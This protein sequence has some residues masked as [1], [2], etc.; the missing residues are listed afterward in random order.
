MVDR[1]Q[2]SKIYCL[3]LT[4]II[5]LT[6][7]SALFA[8]TAYNRENIDNPRHREYHI[9]K[10][11][12]IPEIDGRLTDS[13]WKNTVFNDNFLQREPVEGAEP[14][15][16]TSIAAMYD[17]DNLYIAVQCFDSDPRNILATEMRRDQ[18]VDDDDCIEIILDTFDDKRSAF[19]FATNALGVRIDGKINDEGKNV[20]TDWD[21]VWRCKASMDENGWS[22]E[23]AIPWQTL[24]FKEGDGVEWNANFVRTIRRK[25]EFVF[26]KLVSQDYGENGKYIMSEAGRIKGFNGL[27]MGGKYEFIPYLTGGIER[28]RQTNFNTKKLSDYGLDI[29]WNL[30]STLTADFTY[31]TDFAQ[32]EADQEKVNL[33]RFSLYFPEKRSFFLE[34]AETWNF[35]HPSYF[36][37]SEIQLFY[38]RRIGIEEGRQVPVIGGTRLQGKAGR[39]SIGFLSLQSERT[40]LSGEETTVVPETNYSAIRLRRDILERSTIGIMLLNKQNSSRYNR[41]VGIDSYLHLSDYFSISTEAAGTFTKKDEGFIGDNSDNYAGHIEMKY[42]SDLW[43]FSASYLDIAENFNAEMGFIRRTDI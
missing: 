20:N 29:K 28:D 42:D 41:S 6:F 25:N 37:Y 35:G 31:N 21:G 36:G 10:T 43:D 4:V 13:A 40:V 8:Q 32:A 14:S 5:I 7:T 33:E 30:T 18:P 16:R 26:W 39:Y 17:D 23:L 11:D 9:V 2:R 22:V 12:A 15:E 19:Y 24:R 3:N 27:K 34:G 38:S 1:L